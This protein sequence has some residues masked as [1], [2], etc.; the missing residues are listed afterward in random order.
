[1]IAN[2]TSGT[3]TFE[4]RAIANETMDM[5][6]ARYTWTVGQPPDCDTANIALTPTADG[7]V[8]QVNPTENYVLESELEVRAG[9]DGDPT[10]VPPE[11]VIGQN[12]RG[13]VR[14]ALPTDAECHLESA[15]LRLFAESSTVGRRIHAIPLT[16]PF[17]ESTL[18]WFNQPG[19]AGAPGER[20]LARARRLHGVGRHRPRPRDDRE[21][22]QPR[23]ADQ[24]LVRER[25][26]GRRPDASSAASS[27]STR[28]RADAAR[29]RA[30]ATSRATRRRLRRRRCPPASSR[31]P[32]TAARC[33]RHTRLSPTT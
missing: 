22:H 26:R 8:D 2:L 14:F 27:S 4:V 16:G 7:W 30:A 10:A 17:K 6:P 15:T 21:R 28:R 29:A 12:A 32:S 33:S 31:R 11:P 13:L 18:T 24:R 25:P 23:L 5:T 1:M 20:R 9:S 3:H 19:A